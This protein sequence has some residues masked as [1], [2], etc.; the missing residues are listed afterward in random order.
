MHPAAGSPLQ[1]TAAPPAT[2]MMPA[3]Y[4]T[5]QHHPP[6]QHQV[7]HTNLSEA[8][9]GKKKRHWVHNEDVCLLQVVREHILSK[10]ASGDCKVPTE[11]VTNIGAHKSYWSKLQW[12]TI[13]REVSERLAPANGRNSKQ[14][15]ERFTN[16]LALNKNTV[17]LELVPLPQQ[18]ASSPELGVA[19]NIFEPKQDGSA[20]PQPYSV[21]EMPANSQGSTWSQSEDEQLLQLQEQHGNKW[22]MVAKYLAHKTDAQV[23]N[24]W[25]SLQRKAS[26]Q[27]ATVPQ[28]VAM[29]AHKARN[30][31]AARLR[32]RQ[33]SMAAAAA[34]A[35]GGV[36]L[37]GPMPTA[38]LPVSTAGHAA[39]TQ[40]PAWPFAGAASGMGPSLPPSA[41]PAVWPHTMQMSLLNRG[42]GSPYMCAASHTAGSGM[43]PPHPCPASRATAG[44]PFQGGE[45]CRHSS[46]EMP[47]VGENASPSEGNASTGHPSPREGG[48]DASLLPP[49]SHGPDMHQPQ[50]PSS[51]AIAAT[52]ASVAEAALQMIA[53]S[54][55]G[56]SE[57]ADVLYAGSDSGQAVQW[58]VQRAQQ[59]HA[60]AS[61]R[62]PYGMRPN[63]YALGSGRAQGSLARGITARSSD[64]TLAGASTHTSGNTS[65][66]GGTDDP[67]LHGCFNLSRQASSV[68]D[69]VFSSLPEG[70][71]EGRHEMSGLV[72]SAAQGLSSRGVAH[73][74]LARTRTGTSST[75]TYVLPTLRL[76]STG[77]PQL[78]LPM[79]GS[80]GSSG[81]A[82][83]TARG[84]TPP[85][86]SSRDSTTDT[87]QK[88]FAGA[89]VNMGVLGGGVST[90]A[91]SE[92]S[93]GGGQQPWAAQEHSTFSTSELDS[94]RL[95]SGR[96]SSPL[97]QQ[98]GGSAPR[99]AGPA[100]VQGGS[101]A[102]VA[103][104]A[105]ATQD[106]PQSHESASSWEQQVPLT[107]VFADS[108][109]NNSTPRGG[110]EGGAVRRFSEGKALQLQPLTN[111]P[112][113]RS[114]HSSS[115]S[116]S[117][118][119]RL[120]CSSAST[121]AGSLM[122]AAA[123]RGGSSS[124]SLKPLDR[125]G[126]AGTPAKLHRR[127]F[128]ASG[129][130]S[131]LGDSNTPYLQHRASAGDAVPPNQ[132]GSS[133]SAS[134][135]SAVPML[136]TAGSA[137]GRMVGRL[138]ALDSAMGTSVHVRSSQ[139][140]AKTS[141][142]KTA[143]RHK[144]SIRTGK[145][146]HLGV[147]SAHGAHSR[148][149][150]GSRNSKGSEVSL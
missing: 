49:F 105:K 86:L 108:A 2:H 94:S 83:D 102:R 131:S 140:T 47:C 53:M 90:V 89:G 42:P 139:A 9:A 91:G 6:N 66:T 107:A 45:E 100:P 73:H 71:V 31:D 87:R 147:D 16:N 11:K 23:K 95:Q 32:A 64:S 123:G 58:A 29:S 79:R 101:A 132:G 77:H 144:T 69:S 17:A 36:G 8:C 78:S 124:Q 41:Q 46:E 67:S 141:K 112:T 119:Q 127:V 93:L 13:A 98:R 38:V 60:G 109:S 99:P 54:G 104:R 133:S 7:H 55:R 30:T 106:R 84:S 34:G 37:H 110:A 130:K 92:F 59:D 12:M 27:G 43:P 65:K 35:G 18:D 51:H 75:S 21:V 63:E 50:A 142:G 3:G 72:P 117:Y 146:V 88:S 82:P 57:A 113:P 97:G 121:D 68:P 96:Q 81:G 39:P 26:R 85:L 150:W 145:T 148:K 116:N 15:R 74:S 62:P 25:Y 143:S 1:Y 61:C 103:L 19:I 4:S 129:S 114:Q 134:P 128:N 118:S 111:V 76:S 52:D 24:R 138:A 126:L 56:S 48:V 14:C 149:A 5:S 22:A 33:A 10:F 44:S 120:T 70:S 125:V 28:V 135:S 40:H 136:H 115:N 20:A 137:G 122:A 80:S